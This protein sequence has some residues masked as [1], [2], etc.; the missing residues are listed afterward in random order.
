MLLKYLKLLRATA[1]TINMSGAL[2]MN[3]AVTNVSDA[4]YWWIDAVGGFLVFTKPAVRIGQ[5]GETGNDIRIM[6]DISA[7]HAELR[8]GEGG[9]ILNA[10]GDV[11]VNGTKAK[12]FLLKDGDTIQ[13]RSV[14]MNYRQ[15]MTWCSTAVLTIASSHRLP[16]SLDGVILLGESC[17]LGSQSDAHV[18]TPWDAPV[19]VSHQKG[20]LWVRGPGPI[21]IDGQEYPER[22]PMSDYSKVRGPWGNFRF[23][24]LERN[25]PPSG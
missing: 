12:S 5:A 10:F 21:T 7:R 17:V 9:N 11:T 13:M 25:P 15:P 24:P 18:P 4:F 8:R 1:V 19:M 14:T 22:G 2:V 16:F 20:R 3:E 23:E 6:A